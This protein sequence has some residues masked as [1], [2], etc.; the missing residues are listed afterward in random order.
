MQLS[1]NQ[2]LL[3]NS[4]ESSKM[5]SEKNLKRAEEIVNFYLH[6]KSLEAS[7]GPA[8]DGRCAEDGIKNAIAK[9]LD[10]VEPQWPSELESTAAFLAFYSDDC[11]DE[12]GEFFEPKPQQTWDACFCWLRERLGK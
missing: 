12:D 7:L 2:T 5:P 11:T 1:F 10:Q 8:P 6:F 3:I 9:A 4:R